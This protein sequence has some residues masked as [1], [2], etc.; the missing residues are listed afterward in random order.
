MISKVTSAYDRFNRHMQ[1]KLSSVAKPA[2]QKQGTD[3]AVT[4]KKTTLRD[5]Q[6][7]QL[8]ET[9]TL[10]NLQSILNESEKSLLQKLFSDRF[11]HY[12]QEGEVLS[13]S[14]TGIN[15]KGYSLD[16]VL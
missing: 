13:E 10:D 6:L 9:G 1:N 11:A 7:N 16:R 2:H 5:Q 4:K 8:R 3:S 14:E 12:S 15:N